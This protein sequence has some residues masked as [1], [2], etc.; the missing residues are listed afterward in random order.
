MVLLKIALFAF[1]TY[2][3]LKSVIRFLLPPAL[4][5][6]EKK[7]R[8]K[9]QRYQNKKEGEVTIQ[10]RNKKTNSHGKGIGEYVD[11]EEIND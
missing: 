9:N 1:A 7:M 5:D 10:K 8:N 11:F 6:L 3:I 4:R 2:Y